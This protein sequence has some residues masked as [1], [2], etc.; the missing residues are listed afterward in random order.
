MPLGRNPPPDEC[1]VRRMIDMF[2][3]VERAVE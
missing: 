3:L 2:D 1:R